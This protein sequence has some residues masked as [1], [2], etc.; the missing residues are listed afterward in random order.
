M[1]KTRTPYRYTLI[2]NLH[3]APIA[4][5]VVTRHL[6]G[7]EQRPSL[8]FMA[9]VGQQIALETKPLDVIMHEIDWQLQLHPK[10]EAIYLVGD[11]EDLD[12]D[13]LGQEVARRVELPISTISVEELLGA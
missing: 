6:Y 9:H 1:P 11:P 8:E 2:V 4:G 5:D 13:A 10:T 7:D 3:Y 12:L